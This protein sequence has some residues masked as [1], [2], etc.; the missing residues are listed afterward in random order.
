MNSQILIL[1]MHENHNLHVAVRIRKNLNKGCGYLSE[2]PNSDCVN[3]FR[4]YPRLRSVA[5]FRSYAATWMLSSYNILIHHSSQYIP[6][7]YNGKR[8]LLTVWLF[9][10]LKFYSCKNSSPPRPFKSCSVCWY[11]LSNKSKKD[12]WLIAIVRDLGERVVR[13]IHQKSDCL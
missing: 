1:I 12:C 8:S 13:K 4:L 11:K 2:L 6:C 5:A 3:G 10:F 7:I 9:D